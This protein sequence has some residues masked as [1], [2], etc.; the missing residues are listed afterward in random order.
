MKGFVSFHPVDLALFDDLIGPLV[1]GPEG[2]PRS[3]PPQRPAA[4]GPA[5]GSRAG[6]RSRS[7]AWSPGVK[8]RRRTPPRTSGS[9]C[10]RTSRRMDYKP[11]EAA[12]RAASA[13]DPDLHLDG[14]PFFIAENSAERVAD[15]GGRLRGRRHGGRRRPGRARP[16]GATRSGAREGGRAGGHRRHLVRPRSIATSLL[17]ALKSLHDLGRLARDGKL[18]ASTASRHARRR[19]AAGRAALARDVH[20]RAGPPVLARA[21]RGR[22]GD[23][24]QAAGVS[25]ARLPVPRMAACSPRAARRSPRS[26]DAGAR[27]AT[28]PSTSARSSRLRRSASCSSSSPA[29]AR[30]SSARR[31]APARVRWRP[32]SSARSRSAPST[33]RSTGTATSR[34][35]ACCRRSATARPSPRGAASSDESRRPGPLEVEPSDTAVHVQDLAGEIQARADPR[36]ER[37]EPHLGERHAARRD[38]GVREARDPRAGTRQA[39]SADRRRGGRPGNPVDRTDGSTP[40]SRAALRPGGREAGAK[41]RAAPP[42]LRRIDRAEASQRRD[43]LRDPAPTSIRNG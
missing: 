5:D 22:T 39:V 18:W 8:R 29:T 32:R 35:R 1:G 19:R 37:V 40:A 27:V 12:R 25:R 42:P 14:R 15:G 11:D 21:R 33:R 2:Q 34:R 23:D 10:G 31:P 3:V 30:G 38:L 6:T 36:L 9:A 4:S 28:G 43:A 26:G 41:P 16:A 7:R 13:F 24:L 17:S 20:P